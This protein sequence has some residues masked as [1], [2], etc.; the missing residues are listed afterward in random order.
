G[1]Y[2]KVVRLG[3]FIISELV[4]ALPLRFICT[5]GCR[6]LCSGCGVNLNRETCRCEASG[7]PRMK[8]LADLKDKIR[9]N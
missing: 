8:K 9:R 1:Y 6:G 4:L 7:D 5:E 3:D 2:R